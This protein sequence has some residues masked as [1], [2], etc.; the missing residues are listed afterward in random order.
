MRTSRAATRRHL[1]TSPFKRPPAPVFEEFASGELVT[2]DKYGL[3]RVLKVEHQAVVIDFGPQKMRITE[4][5]ARLFK[6]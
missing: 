1:P 5:Y 3:G 4:P 2:H 6:L